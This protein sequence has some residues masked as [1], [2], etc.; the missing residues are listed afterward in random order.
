MPH[1]LNLGCVS[2]LC[3]VYPMR[4]ST[5]IIIVA[6]IFSTLPF[7]AVKAEVGVEPPDPIV[8][9]QRDIRIENAGI[10]WVTDEFTLRAS[11]EQ[12]IEISEF[13]T[14]FH[15]FFSSERRS[16][17][18]WEGS[19]WTPLT[20]EE[21]ANEGFEGYKLTLPSPVKLAEGVYSSMTG[22]LSLRIRASY[23]F[24]DTVFEGQD[25][26][27]A[28][29]PVYPALTYNASTFVFHAE[30]PLDAEFELTV[31]DLNFTGS[32]ESGVWT[33]GYENVS[34][35][36][37]ANENATISYAPAPGDEYILEC[38]RLERKITV[39]QGSMRVEDS[40]TIVNT[41]APKNI[42]NLILPLEASDIEGRDGVGPLKVSS[43]EG[44]ERIDAH[45]STRWFLI[46][47]DRL[48]F[49][50]SYTM[51]NSGYVTTSGGVSTLSY[52]NSDF[53]FYV[54]ELVA[55]V[56]RPESESLSLEYGALLPSERPEILA[57]LPPASIMPI[58]RPYAGLLIAAVAV[59]AV[60][61]LRRRKP[62]ER[63]EMKPIEVEM[64]KLSEFIA[65]NMER[66]AM[67][68]EVE[69]LETELKEGR[70]SRDEF[71]QSAAGINRRLGELAR[72]L[73]QLGRTIESEDPDLAEKLTGIRRAEGELER[74][75]KDL[76]NLD[77]RLR[78]RRVSRRDY[79]RRR[80][81]RLRRR[82]EALK[83]IEQA[84]RSL[85]SGD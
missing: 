17:E 38:E 78:A 4:R 73:R 29:V 11:S 6:I 13:W 62:R 16:F 23:L 40:Y 18:V 74:I 58:V 85:G 35:P 59:G 27:S 2:L 84:L 42:I 47:G 82:S 60:L 39:K 8:D 54:R 75:E 51:P 71:N 30:L 24:V 32:M 44:E 26:F 57:E 46:N 31:S 83:R 14:G 15:P 20:F 12:E 3:T 81:D 10:V 45:V 56:T 7:Q 76:R 68:R 9:V 41:G 77:V 21:E 33:V 65:Q 50:L 19:D 25:T 28:W 36:A 43:E 37:Y 48:S 69:D 70:I 1:V 64:P 66:I 49:T 63:V 55:V 80:G 34:I 61:M 72:S 52:P 22:E 5:A 67:F 79:E 53:P